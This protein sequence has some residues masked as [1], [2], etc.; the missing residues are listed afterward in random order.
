MLTKGNFTRDEWGNFLHL[1]NISHFSYT[2]CAK[3]SSLMSCTITVAKRMQGETWEV[4]I[5][6]K[7]ESTAMNLSS[8][9]PT[10]CSS[11]KVR[12]HPIVRGYS[13]LRGSL[14]A[15][16]EEIRNPTQ[17]RV[18]KCGCKMHTLA[19]WWTHQRGNLSQQKRSQGIWT[20][21]QEEAVTERPI[22]NETATGKPCAS[23][24]PDCQ[25]GP[26]AVRKNGHTIFMCLQPQFT[27]R[28]QSSR[29]SGRST[30]E[31]MT[32]LWM[33]WTWI[34]LFGGIFLNAT[35]QAAV[36]LGQ[37]YEANLRIVKNHLWNSVKQLFNETEKL[38]SGQI[39]ITGA[40]TIN[41]RELAWMSTSL[42]CS[43]AYQYTN[44]KGCV[45]S[46]S[47][48]CVGKMGDDPI[49]TWK[50]KIKCIWE[51][52]TS[53]IWIESTACRR[54]SSGKYSQESQRWASSRRFKV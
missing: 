49:A 22:A 43:K 1:F 46:G 36:D 18:L 45:F 8:H 10:R 39:Q 48:L 53:K 28:K 33:M 29:S 21:S 30:D 41:F 50:S 16:W 19:G 12:L 37:D 15:A 51:P 52:I 14:K 25:G 31:N 23:S 40:N 11:A 6:A 34:W 26:K 7:S 4:R 54:S 13:Q 44:A 47:V 5:V 20:W 35:L 17:R 2:C 9:V 24:K 38:I 3:N 27:I 42:L 32:T